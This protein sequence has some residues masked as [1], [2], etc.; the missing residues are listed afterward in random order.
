MAERLIGMM[1]GTKDPESSTAMVQE[2]IDH[3]HERYGL[4]P[5]RIAVHESQVDID[6]EQ[7]KIDFFAPGYIIK[8]NVWLLVN[9]E[10]LAKAK[11]KELVGEEE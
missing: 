9:E 5:T 8:N 1:W 7:I 11:E 6:I 2:A 4:T 10:A 3:L